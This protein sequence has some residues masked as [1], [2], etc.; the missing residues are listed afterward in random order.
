MSMYELDSPEVRKFL[1]EW[2]DGDKHQFG[3]YRNRHP[4][5]VD[6]YINFIGLSFLQ[7]EPA[8][9]SVQPIGKFRKMFWEF[10]TKED[11]PNVNYDSPE[12]DTVWIQTLALANKIREHGAEP[13]VTYSGRRGFHVWAYTV[14]LEI[15][16]DNERKG[17]A[18]YKR[19]IYDIIGDIKKY[20]DIDKMPLHANAMARIPFSF[21]QKSGNQ[22]VP[23]TMNREPYIP[24]LNFHKENCLDKLYISSH[25]EAVRDKMA[26]QSTRTSVIRDWNIRPCLIDRFIRKP[27]HHVN[28]ALVIDAIYAEK[29]DEEIH[30]IYKLGSSYDEGKT[31][32][33]I[34]YQREQIR[35]QGYKPVSKDRLKEWG[36]CDEEE[37]KI[38]CGKEA[39]NP[40]KVVPQ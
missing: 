15:R 3:Q 4:S 9:Q 8:F 27:D 18:L 37:C 32:Y 1:G 20:P 30:D 14:E 26:K 5:D 38:G 16:E 33:Q 23:L 25:L 2:F 10:D 11:I 19:V 21:H 40:W 31:Q 17:K 39:F 7:Q 6:G 35:E 34:D 29:T 36:I 28:L 24:D 12:L 13:M 22:V